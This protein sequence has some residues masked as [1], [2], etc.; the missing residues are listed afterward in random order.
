MCATQNENLP[1]SCS[2]ASSSMMARNGWKGEVGSDFAGQSCVQR[3]GLMDLLRW[4]HVDMPRARVRVAE[5]LPTP[6]CSRQS[7]TPMAISCS[8]FYGSLVLKLEVPLP[9]GVVRVLQVASG[10][11][12]G[13]E[14]E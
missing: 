2:Y 11:G 4:R 3:A 10:W 9:M 1:A 5:S 14:W 8:L 13:G 6:V 7:R 12:W